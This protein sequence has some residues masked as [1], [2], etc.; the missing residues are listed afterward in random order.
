MAIHQNFSKIK[1]GVRQGCPLSALLFILAVEILS[2]KLRHDNSIHGTTINGKEIK[3]TQLADDTTLFLKDK[4]SLERSL[5][6]LEDFRTCSGLSLNYTKTEILPIGKPDLINI[7]VRIV[8]KALSLGI[9][10]YDNIEEIIEANHK[11]KFAELEKTLTNW[12]K[13]NL[14]LIG[15]KHSN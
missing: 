12:R 14:T 2:I 13:R 1:C 6:L 15:K 10:Y 3:L 5:K 11:N 7:P 8:N 4:M 9:W